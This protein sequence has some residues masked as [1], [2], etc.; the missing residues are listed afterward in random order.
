MRRVNNSSQPG[1][2]NI[3]E[4]EDFAFQIDN[5]QLKKGRREIMPYPM[6]AKIIINHFLSKHQSLTKLQYLHTHTIKDDGVVSR[7]KFVRIGKDFQEYGLSI[8]K[9]ILTEGIKQ[10]K[11]YQMFIKYSTGLIPPKKSRDDN[12]ILD[13]DIALELGKSISLTDAAEEEAARQVHATHERIM[14]ESDPEPL[15]EDHRKINRSQPHAGGSSEGTGSKP[16]VPDESIVTPTSSNEG[17]DTKPESEY[18][19]EDND[20]ENIEWVDT[21]EEEENNDDDDDKSIDL[22]KTNDEETNDEFVHSK[23]YVQDDNEETDDESVHGDEQVNDYEDDE[24]TNAKDADTGNGGEEITDAAKANAEKTEEVKD[25]IKKAELPPSGSSLSVSLDFDNQFLDLS[26]DTSLIVLTPIPKTPLV[27]PA[28]TLLPTIPVSFIS[29]VLLQTITP[30]PTP[31]ITTKAPPVTMIPD[32][33]YAIIQRVFVLEKDVQEL[34]EYPQQVDYKEIIK[35][36][37]Q[38]NIISVVKNQLLKFLPKEASD[39]ATPMIQS[40]S[41]SEYELKTIL[42]DKM[43]KSRSYLTHD[44]HQA[45]FDALF[46]LLSLE[47]A[48]IRGQADLEKILRKRDRDDEYPSTGPNQEEPVFEMAFD[49]IEQTIDDVAN[50]AYQPPDDSTQTKD[51]A[52]KKDWFK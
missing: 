38:A 24:M 40:T 23:E 35:E 29:H 33:L 15:E 42:F 27:A 3:F 52:I 13:P 11:S 50:N 32:P 18:T 12:I 7:L 45:L 19:E 46:N 25:D 21:N 49:D 37:V 26:S 39:F 2:N 14:T 47:D 51:K 17:T 34:K 48:I 30:I 36:S 9:T 20:D 10:S 16:R 6:F 31:P 8:P 4:E 22:E 41:L 28:S 43:D 1:I 44:K 5:R